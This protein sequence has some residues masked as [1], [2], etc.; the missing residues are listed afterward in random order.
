MSASA[1]ATLPIGIATPFGDGKVILKNIQGD[2]RT[3]GPFQ[4]TVELVSS[5]DALDF[6]KIVGKGVTITMPLASGGKVY[7]H[8]IV[9]RFVHAGKNVRYT[10]Y[11]ADIHP[12]FWL[13]TLTSDCKIFQNKTAIEIVKQVLSDGGVTDVKDATTRTYATREYCVQFN[14][15]S[16]NFVSRLLE[17]E[18]AFYF[19]DHADGKH[20]M[21][22]AD[23]SS[24]Y[25]Q[26]A[27]SEIHVRG[28]MASWGDEDSLTDCSI[29]EQSVVKKYQT[30]D[31]NFQ[32]PSTSLLGSA[33]GNGTGA[34]YEYPANLDSKS[35]VD[36]RSGVALAAFESTKRILR[37]ST[38]CRA[39]GPGIRFTLTDH[40]R[41]DVNT[42]YVVTGFHFRA[43]QSTM[44][45]GSVEAIPTA[46]EFHPRRVTPRP[47]IAGSQTATVVGKS[48]EEI[49][50]DKYGRIKVHFHWDQLGR[51]D[52]ND[53]CWIRVAQGWAGK[54]WGNIF[55]PRIG[56]E[57]IVSFLDGN[58]DRPI[59]TGCVY[60]GEN[61]VPYT[62]PDEQ[63]KS[64]MKSNSSKGGGGFNEVRFEDKKD[65]E[66]IYIHAQKDHT[67]E[68]LHDQKTTIGNDQTITIKNNRTTTIQEKDETLIVDKGNRAVKVN[69][70]NETHEVK[71]KRDLTVTGKET[72]TNKA[73]YE[74][75]VGGNFTL[76]VQGNISIEA[77][78]SVSIKS[79][80]SFENQAGTS[81]TNKAGTSLENN[82]GTSLTNKAGTTMENNAQIQLTNKAGATQTVDGGGML[83]LKGGMV[84]IN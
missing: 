59:V 84:K 14:E 13:L 77:Q 50:T 39:F 63:T 32:T 33:E 2:E 57:V 80:T 9:T 17:E 25:I 22:L 24:A 82:A 51:R 30:T 27:Y 31:Y 55:I 7:R 26:C 75:T 20:T 43:D 34:I 54:S 52:E 69:T 41:S 29:E 71:G 58:P 53:S 79:G 49:W 74:M 44:F 81:L 12:Q 83:T 4:Y 78:G 45:T 16:F 47:Y 64:T 42:E 1:Q 67:V 37:G 11:I 19:F 61:V 60:N 36:T 72:H 5:D 68:I 10:T 70:G 23:D 38:G 66:E 15:T 6:S 40:S 65:A 18:G 56:Q 46:A 48:G 28:T 73:D 76:K 8:G 3:A 35:D 62:L 21:V